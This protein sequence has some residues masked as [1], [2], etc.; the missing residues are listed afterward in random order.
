MKKNIAFKK[1]VAQ[2]VATLL[3]YYFHPKN[4]LGPYK[5]SPKFCHSFGLLFFPKIFLWAFTN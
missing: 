5:S 2:N 1:K 3:G 4:L